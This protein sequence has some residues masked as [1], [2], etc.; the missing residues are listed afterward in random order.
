MTRNVI[1]T[2]D[3]IVMTEYLSIVVIVALLAAF[4]VLLVK[5]W[6]WAEWMQVHGDRIMSK[7]F[8]CDLCMCFWASV[9]CVIIAT[10]WVDEVR[11]MAVPFLSTPLARYLQ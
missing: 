9:L 4:I 6:G 10:I 11:M 1:I 5:K 3:E 2:K 8:S 7:L